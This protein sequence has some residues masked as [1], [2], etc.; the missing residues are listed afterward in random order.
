MPCS[1]VE[2]GAA[3]GYPSFTCIAS[4][5]YFNSCI[6]IA[7]C[8]AGLFNDMDTCRDRLS[9]ASHPMQHCLTA[10]DSA[11]AANQSSRMLL[12]VPGR[13]HLTD[14]CVQEL[15]SASTTEQQGLTCQDGLSFRRTGSSR[16]GG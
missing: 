4:P 15:T 11:G 1:T 6:G 13:V 8:P 14:S 2:V 10:T 5:G 9:C 3:M 7:H 16:G 12:V